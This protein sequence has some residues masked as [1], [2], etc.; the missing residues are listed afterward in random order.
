MAAKVVARLSSHNWH[1]NHELIELRRQGYVPY[2]KRHDPHFLPKPMRISARSESCEALTALSMALAANCDYNPDSD[3][4]FEIMAP[5]EQIAASMGMLHVYDNGRKAYDSPLHALSV[6]EQLGYV[7]ALH[8][9]DTDSGQNKPLR[10]WLTEKFFISRGIAVEEI[11]QWLGQ[12]RTW[13]IKNGL[14][15][16]LRQKYE[17]H[18]LRVERIGIDLKDKHSLRNRLKQIKRWVVSP[19]LAKEKQAK[20]DVLERGLETL[21]RDGSQRLDLILDETQQKIRSLAKAKHQ[22]QNPYYQAFVKWSTSGAV[23]THD[24]M[25]QEQALQKEQLGLKHSDPETFY[26]LLLERAGIV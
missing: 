15:E 4:P 11:R 12:F 25:M 2:T 13:A 1:R 17:R 14:T 19:D 3:Y 9:K 6:Q 23:M 7:I 16:S 22:R 10:L 26:R 8:G 18:L 21:K 5:F 24:V 20:V